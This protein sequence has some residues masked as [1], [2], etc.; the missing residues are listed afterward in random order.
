MIRAALIAALALGLAS[1]VML[2]PRAQEPTASQPTLPMEALTIASKDG[3]RHPF[4]VEVA[5]TAAE[6]KVGEMFRTSVPPD[7]GMLFV[8]TKPRNI[9]MWMQNTLV[10]LD[11]VFI[12]PNGTISR[13]ED[14]A[15]PQSLRII[16]SGGP[17]AATLELA[18]GTAARLGIAVGDKVV[19]PRFQGG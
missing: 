5:T 19:G 18:G 16:D 12:E 17:V 1:T 9:Q 4:H 14:D 10:P 2:V 15:V 11:M 8:W 6:Q 3:Q 7:G 13:I